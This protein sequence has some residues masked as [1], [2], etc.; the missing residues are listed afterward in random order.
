MLRSRRDRCKPRHYPRR[1][2][3]DRCKAGDSI[4]ARRSF[5][6]SR[7]RARD[8]ERADG[9]VS[10]RAATGRKVSAACDSLNWQLHSARGSFRLPFSSPVPLPRSLLSLF[11][12]RSLYVSESVGVSLRERRICTLLAVI[13]PRPAP[14]PLTLSRNPESLFNPRDERTRRWPRRLV[15]DRA[16]SAPRIRT[17]RLSPDIRPYRARSVCGQTSGFGGERP[18][19]LNFN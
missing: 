15:G 11:L 9:R 5:V 16:D 17:S 2:R 12:A 7:A 10:E 18:P 13:P 4:E 6:S 19:E 14:P 8:S 1:K 3:T